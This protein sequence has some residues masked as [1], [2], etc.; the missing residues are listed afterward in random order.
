MWLSHIY[1]CCC[2]YG[3]ARFAEALSHYAQAVERNASHPEL[4]LNII[5]LKVFQYDESPEPLLSLFE[6]PPVVHNTVS[7]EESRRATSI[8]GKIAVN[9]EILDH[10]RAAIK[11]QPHDAHLHFLMGQAVVNGSTLR[12]QQRLLSHHTSGPAGKQFLLHTREQAEQIWASQQRN[13]SAEGTT[14]RTDGMSRECDHYD[15]CRS[16]LRHI[17]P[18]VALAAA[19]GRR[20][21]RKAVGLNKSNAEYMFA[22]ALALEGEALEVMRNATPHLHHLDDNHPDVAHVPFVVLSN[23]SYSTLRRFQRQA[24][25]T[26]E[27]AFALSRAQDSAAFGVPRGQSGEATATSRTSSGLSK[28]HWHEGSRIDGQNSDSGDDSTMATL[29]S[30]MLFRLRELAVRWRLC[31]LY[32]GTNNVE[33]AAACFFDAT[34]LA[35]AFVGLATTRPDQADR[36]SAKSHEGKA[37]AEAHT[38]SRFLSSNFGT[39][40]REKER[41]Y[42]ES[43]ALPP[44]VFGRRGRSTMH[45]HTDSTEQHSKDPRDRAAEPLV[46]LKSRMNPLVACGGQRRCQWALLWSELA[47]SHFVLGD[48]L[49]ARHVLAAALIEWPLCALL[50]RDMA[51]VML[52]LGSDSESERALV[53][54]HINWTSQ[55]NRLMAQWHS[56]QR[57]KNGHRSATGPNDRQPAPDAHF[58]NQGFDLFAPWPSPQPTDAGDFMEL[59]GDEVPDE[60]V[61]LTDPVKTHRLESMPSA[62]HILRHVA[63]A[64]IIG[65]ASLSTIPSRVVDLLVAAAG[66]A[67]LALLGVVFATQRA[68]LRHPGKGGPHS[69]ESIAQHYRYDQDSSAQSYAVGRNTSNRSEE[70]FVNSHLHDGDHAPSDLRSATVHAEHFARL[71]VAVESAGSPNTTDSD[72][73]HDI[74]RDWQEYLRGDSAHNSICIWLHEAHCTSSEEGGGWYVNHSA[75]SV[76]SFWTNALRAGERIGGVKSLQCNNDGHVGPLNEA[77]LRLGEL[78][79]LQGHWL[80]AANCFARVEGDDLTTSHAQ[81]RLANIRDRHF[82][83]AHSTESSSQ[84]RPHT[85]GESSLAED[86]FHPQHWYRKV[87]TLYTSS[88]VVSPVIAQVLPPLSEIQDVETTRVGASAANVTASDPSVA[89]AQYYGLALLHLRQASS[90]SSA[91]STTRKHAVNGKSSLTGVVCCATSSSDSKQG[92]CDVVCLPAVRRAPFFQLPLLLD[93]ADFFERHAVRNLLVRE[94]SAGSAARAVSTCQVADLLQNES[95]VSLADFA[96]ADLTTAMKNA[97]AAVEGPCTGDGGGDDSQSAGLH[98]EGVSQDGGGG[99]AEGCDNTTPN[100]HLG[101]CTTSIFWDAATDLYLDAAQSYPDSVQAQLEAV[102]ALMRRGQW[103]TAMATLRRLVAELPDPERDPHRQYNAL[104]FQPMEQHQYLPQHLLAICMFQVCIFAQH[105]LIFMPFFQARP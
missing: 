65:S 103:G 47:A 3:L 67:D 73:M 88:S 9:E 14:N 17:G 86:P 25:F 74:L 83:S 82:R 54:Q 1:A 55:E 15:G 96:G 21:F 66:N 95:V 91:A 70:Q 42:Q 23:E 24:I 38:S 72:T 99:G 12:N 30:H 6:P 45:T 40:R 98:G 8:A 78:L 44:S 7:E 92:P 51:A 84:P 49:S 16:L 31:R 19:R 80:A 81:L 62:M 36:R 104:K 46:G 101:A 89:L 105:V 5:R 57:L 33:K 43:R 94:H 100:E 37:S 56:L 93:A 77:L 60:G 71:S 61:F 29:P 26:Y 10:L 39:T 48:P 76:P 64:Q 75:S 68:V 34:E 79:R 50:H 18:E 102:E 63:G 22:L 27:T 52:A 87:K 85:L 69:R 28:K 11:L 20:H 58:Q 97:A 32:M 59:V 35:Q 2:C 53:F 4:R 13:S 90:S 41:K